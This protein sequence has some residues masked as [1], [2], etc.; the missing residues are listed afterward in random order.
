MKLWRETTE[1]KEIK[2]Y[3][4]FNCLWKGTDVKLIK[5]MWKYTNKYDGFSIV[6]NREKIAKELNIFEDVYDDDIWDKLVKELN[7][8]YIEN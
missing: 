3:N 7:I 5:N 1:K 4:N 8:K 2:K 6:G